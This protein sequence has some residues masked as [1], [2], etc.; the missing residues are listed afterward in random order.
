MSVKDRII[1]VI[2]FKRIAVSA[3]ESKSGLS[4]GYI[5]N[6]KD[7][8]SAV[9]LEDIL[10]AYPDINRVWLL[11]GEGEMLHSE[12]KTENFS[13]NNS[14]VSNVSGSGNRIKNEV[15]Q[16]ANI[17]H[18]LRTIDDKEEIIALLKEKNAILQDKAELQNEII[19]A[20][21]RDIKELTEQC[22]HLLGEL[23]SKDK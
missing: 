12:K 14:G 7:A 4:N 9:K 3:F 16:A 18:L 15:T 5:K 1:E 8:P 13:E 2:N 19:A 20:K 22:A 6:L 23:T 21:S 17:D 11:T 10:N